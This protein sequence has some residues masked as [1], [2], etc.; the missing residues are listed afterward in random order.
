MLVLLCRYSGYCAW[1]GVFYYSGNEDSETI[2]DIR[3]RYPDLGKCLYFDMGFKTH[4][5]LYEIPNKKL[6]WIWYINQPEPQ[7]KVLDFSMSI[8]QINSF[9]LPHYFALCFQGTSV[10]MKVSNDMINK[11]H[12][13]ADKIWAPEFSKLIKETRD[14]FINVIYDCDPL[15]RI[16]WDNVVL[17]GDAAH[18]TT[19]HGVRSTNMSIL[20]AAVLGKCLHKWGPQNLALALEEY[21]S[22]R[23]PVT[24]KQVLHSRHLGRIK[25]GLSLPDQEPFDLQTAD[26]DYCQQ[27]LQRNM[28][29][30]SNA[31]LSIH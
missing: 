27:L 2:Q 15:Q 5:V 26:L 29:F 1:R 14:P 12:Q 8:S 21:Q 19:P 3:R 20:D 13:E 22:I 6:N 31:T 7:L 4:S 11:M 16:F 18:P 17:V 30:F 10:T 28:P 9:P 23:L 25:Q 24:S